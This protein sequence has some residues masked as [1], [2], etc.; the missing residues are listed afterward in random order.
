MNAA[1]NDSSRMNSRS[2][3][4]S[5]SAASSSSPGRRRASASA[6]GTAASTRTAATSTSPSRPCSGP[7][8]API[9][10]AQRHRQE[11]Q[12][13]RQAQERVAVQRHDQVF[14][15]QP[16]LEHVRIFSI[17]ANTGSSTNSVDGTALST[18]SLNRF[19]SCCMRA[20][21]SRRVPTCVVEPAVG[22]R[23]AASR[24]S[25]G[26]VFASQGLPLK[27]RWCCRRLRRRR[28]RFAARPA[29]R[30]AA[31]RC[32]ARPC[33]RIAVAARRPGPRRTPGHVARSR[34]CACASSRERRRRARVS[35]CAT[36]VALR[37]RVVV[38]EV[39]SA[40]A[41]DARA[42]AARRRT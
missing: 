33:A 13:Q 14:H 5:T 6:A 27:S 39:G 4:R 41:A 29:A 25:S 15:V 24:T 18:A 22:E 23:R 42:S 16:A 7:T 19:G 20:M 26:L 34:A 30:A 35:T 12:Q 38:A 9:A 28:R 11:H 31:R 17:S 3:A 1:P 10:V 37:D 2:R 8:P 21:L 36:V 40:V 32:G